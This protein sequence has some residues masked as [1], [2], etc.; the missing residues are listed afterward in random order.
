MENI[1]DTP[2]LIHEQ[3]DLKGSTIG[4]LVEIDEYDPNIALKD[5]NFKRK[6]NLGNVTV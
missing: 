6:I 2:L 3:Y 5:Q 4:R 1:F